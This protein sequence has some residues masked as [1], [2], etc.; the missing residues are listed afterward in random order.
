MEITMDRYRQLTK[1]AT[2]QSGQHS[3]EAPSDVVCA[4]AALVGDR[5]VEASYI[6]YTPNGKSTEWFGLWIIGGGLAHV[7]VTYREQQWTAIRE[8]DQSLGRYS[9]PTQ[10]CSWYR[11]LDS[12]DRLT[13]GQVQGYPTGTE[14][15]FKLSGDV[16]LHFRDSSTPI[17]LGYGPAHQDSA[18][19][20]L[21]KLRDWVGQQR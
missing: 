12:I 1:L 15:S 11:S 14:E 10:V 18:D 20:L 16:T 9:K 19:E 8:R 13:Y 3:N 2:T 21:L 7:S 17:T 5:D 4:V 6:R